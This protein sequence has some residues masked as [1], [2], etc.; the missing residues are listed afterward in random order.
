[1]FLWEGDTGVGYLT[2]RTIIPADGRWHT[3][4]IRFTDFSL[5][6]AN[7]PDANG[8]LDRDQ[9]RRVSIGMNSDAADN[10]LEVSDVYVMP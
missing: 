5:S 7:A 8:R 2:S 10:E 4:T 1:M 3:A 6:G 9:V